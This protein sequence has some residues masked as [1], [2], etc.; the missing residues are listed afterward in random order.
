MT[1]SQTTTEAKRPG[2][3][4]NVIWGWFGVAVNLAIGILL[5]PII[6]RKLGVDRYGVWVLVFSVM[7]YMR[8]LDFGFRAAVVNACARC[9][10]REDWA[11]I[12]RVLL[13]SLLY[14]FCIGASCT[15]IA[16][17]ARQPLLARLDISGPLSGEASTLIVIVAV[18]VSLRLVVSPVT[19]VLE[20]FVRFDLLN[21]AY[22]SALLFRSIGSLVA[23][24]LGYGLVEMAWLVLLAQAG[25]GLYVAVKARQLLPRF[26]I[27]RH[28]IGRDVWRRLFGYGK[29]S[30][31]IA[32]ANLVSIN[33]PATALGYFRTAAEVGFFA[34]PFRLL[35][36]SAEGLAKVSDVTA[37]VTAGLD[38]RGDKERVWRLA[39][40]TNRHCFALFIPVA[41]F[42]SIYGGPLLKLW[43]TPAVAENSAK[44]LPILVLG[45]LFGIA[46]QYNAGA[47]LIGQGRHAAYAY[48]ALVEAGGTIACLA[49][50]VP[51]FGT[52]GAA[53]VVTSAIALGRGAYLAIAL[54]RINNFSITRYVAAVYGPGLATAMPVVLFALLLRHQVWAGSSWPELVMAGITVFSLYFGLAFFSV[55][56]HEHRQRIVRRL[57]HAVGG[58]R[59][60]TSV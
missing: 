30:A 51:R 21:R 54:C 41:I 1:T 29:Y 35:M 24:F 55:L 14:F 4:Q 38:E 11:G 10:E 7:D 39:V 26:E 33:A 9:R 23:L 6:I 13:T 3:L 8:V 12:N 52:V 16:L 18:A 47:I 31:I 56:Q 42:L 45:F 19:A 46:G 43:V 48:G 53:W 27:G 60:V 49:F 59:S 28:A 20:A 37:A 22:V 36:Y 32:G 15:L 40:L 17:L 25:E 57:S 2:F 50:A 34:L 44:L 58:R 5:M